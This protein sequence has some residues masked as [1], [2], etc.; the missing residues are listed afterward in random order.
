MRDSPLKGTKARS[1]G[2]DNDQPK[3]MG[4]SEQSEGASPLFAYIKSD[5]LVEIVTRVPAKVPVKVCI[6]APVVL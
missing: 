2:T 5:S 3:K 6:T 1:Q 4:E